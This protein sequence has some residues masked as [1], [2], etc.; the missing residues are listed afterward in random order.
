M[1]E[2]QRY[3]RLEVGGGA[4]CAAI[5]EC[6]CLVEEE[7]VVEHNPGRRPRS[8]GVRDAWKNLKRS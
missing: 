8:H 6:L 1:G 5:Y 4:F 3:Q 2:D 7:L